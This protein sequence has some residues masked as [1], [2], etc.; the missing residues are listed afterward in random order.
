MT[1]EE[2]KALSDVFNSLSGT[3]IA[4]KKAYLTIDSINNKKS[5]TSMIQNKNTPF[6]SFSYQEDK[7]LKYRQSMEDIGIM[8]PDLTTDYK[9]SL[10]GIFDGHGGND[11]VKFIKDRI[12]QLIKNYLV[13][14]CP[15]EL[16]FKK[17]FQKADEELKFFDSEYIGTTATIIL[18]KDNKIYCANVGDSKAFILYNKN[19]KQ[20]SSDHKCSSEEEVERIKKCGGKISKNRVMG[21]LILTRTLGDL[22]VKKF[23]VISTPDITVNDISSGGGE[24]KYVVLAS[25][26]VW[27]VVDLDTLLSMSKANKPVGEFCQDIVKLSINK[28]TKD[29]V[30]CIVISFVE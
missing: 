6:K 7:N 25:D 23:G 14:L 2:Q 18:I 3:S 20:I 22:Y 13:D 30:S 8:I 12:P 15:V 28:G 27:D 11:V 21:Q 10:F 1:N 5:G 29:N 24:I 26:G 4:P 19:Y 9:V 16:A 17:A